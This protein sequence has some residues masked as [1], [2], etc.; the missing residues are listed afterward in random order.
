MAVLSYTSNERDATSKNRLWTLTAVAERT[1]G[2]DT[3]EDVTQ[4]YALAYDPTNKRL[5]FGCDNPAELRFQVRLYNQAGQ[6]LR[7]FRA[8]DGCDLTDLPQAIYIVSWTTGKR[9]H[10]IKFLR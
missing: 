9:T 2:I 6:L 7:T 10:S 1:D 4:D 3:A 8:N 5:H